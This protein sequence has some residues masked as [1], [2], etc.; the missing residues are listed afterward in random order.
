MT[1]PYLGFDK[2]PDHLIFLIKLDLLLPQKRPRVLDT[3]CAISPWHRSCITFKTPPPKSELHCFGKPETCEIFIREMTVTIERV[4]AEAIQINGAAGESGETEAIQING[5]DGGG[6]TA[7]IERGEARC[8][9]NQRSRR[10]A[11]STATIERG[12]T[13]IK[14]NGAAGVGV[15][16][17]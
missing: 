12:N 10:W 1:I 17:E 8:Y 15:R 4:G 14:I 3:Q 6:S 7:T 11:D 16:R 9:T 2:L 5:A 13:A